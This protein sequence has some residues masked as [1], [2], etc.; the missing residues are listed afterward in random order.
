[1]KHRNPIAVALLPFVTLGIYGI[2]WEVKTKGEMV[3]LGADIP[4]AWLLIVPFVNIWWLWKYSQ[5]VEKVTGG[6]LS[7]VL[8]FILL[9]LLGSIGA[10]IVQDSFNNNVVTEPA[11]ATPPTPASAVPTDNPP[12]P[13]AP[14]EPPTVQSPTNPVQ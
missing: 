12:V 7:G 4:T 3:A 13:P 1:M 2:Y 11:V 8:A 5:G 10:A 9:W 6:K 14:V